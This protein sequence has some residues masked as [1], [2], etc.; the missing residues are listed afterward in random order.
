MRIRAQ[1]F[2]W[3]SFWHSSFSS[4]SEYRY[5]VHILYVKIDVTNQGCSCMVRLAPRLLPEGFHG[6][7]FS[8]NAKRVEAQLRASL[9]CCDKWRSKPHNLLL[10]TI[11]S[12]F[13]RSRMNKRATDIGPLRFWPIGGLVLIP[14]W[15]GWLRLEG[16]PV[17]VPFLWVADGFGFFCFFFGFGLCFLV[18]SIF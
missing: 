13:P 4:P 6:R 18:W 15:W 3:S 16:M 11:D 8:T 9:P 7:Y 17:W 12:F 10:E 5:I 2:I 1:F 14:W